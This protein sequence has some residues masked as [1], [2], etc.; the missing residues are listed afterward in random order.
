MTA[1]ISA[2]DTAGH[3]QESYNVCTIDHIVQG[4]IMQ[5]SRHTIVR[6]VLLLTYVEAAL[7]SIQQVACF[8]STIMSAKESQQEAMLIRPAFLLFD[9]PVSM[10]HA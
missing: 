10:H 6:N 4:R 2:S 7:V 5:D 8:Q 1:A 3:S 9:A